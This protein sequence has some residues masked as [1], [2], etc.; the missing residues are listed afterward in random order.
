LN[1]LWN[2]FR[3]TTWPTECSFVLA[4]ISATDCGLKAFSR[5]RMLTAR[6]PLSFAPDTTGTGGGPLLHCTT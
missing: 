1:P 6:L 2:R 4:P 3:A 5:F